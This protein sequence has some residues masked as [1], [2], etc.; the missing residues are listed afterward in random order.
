MKS[1]LTALVALLVTGCSYT[2]DPLKNYCAEPDITSAVTGIANAPSPLPDVTGTAPASQ[3]ASFSNGTIRGSLFGSHYQVMACHGTLTRAD[4]SK[5]EGV[6]VTR[7]KGGP[8]SW[9]AL[10][11][12]PASP[13]YFRVWLTD[14]QVATYREKQITDKLNHTPAACKPY[15]EDLFRNT[16]QTGLADGKLRSTLYTCLAASGLRPATPPTGINATTTSATPTFYVPYYLD[17]EM[18]ISG[19]QFY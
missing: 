9:R 4:G 18:E 6:A 8:T 11:L 10:W 2:V 5:E 1:R 14:A 15:A 3:A 7:L 13:D 16:R 17:P 19:L 12:D